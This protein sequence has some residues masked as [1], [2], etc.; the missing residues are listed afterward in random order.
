MSNKN[1]GKQTSDV[2]FHFSE[3][4]ENKAKC[5]YC[6]QILKISN[7]STGNLIRHIKTKHFSI[8]I[9]RSVRSEPNNE[10]RD[11]SPSEISNNNGDKNKE[12]STETFTGNSQNNEATQRQ[13]QSMTDTRARSQAVEISSDEDIQNTPSPI[14]ERGRE[15]V[16]PRPN[17][18]ARSQA[19]EISSDEDIQNTPSPII[20]RGREDVRPRPKSIHYE[21][22]VRRSTTPL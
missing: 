20:E 10:S 1:Q 11:P 15:D 6:A 9:Y 14:I 8:P 18:R 3:L 2:W 4:G 17:T 12:P 19:V 13:Q 16:R 5:N 22:R 21:T 7:R